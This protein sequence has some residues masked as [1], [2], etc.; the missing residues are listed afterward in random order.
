MKHRTIEALRTAIG[1]RFLADPSIFLITVP[2]WLLISVLVVPNI[3]D[4]R[5]M[6]AAVLGNLLS[7]AAFFGLLLVARD[8]VFRD[9]HLRPVSL[10]QVAL[11]GAG[12]GA[13][14]GALSVWIIDWLVPSLDYFALLPI[15]IASA[16]LVG[17]TMLAGGSLILSMRARFQ[18][19]NEALVASVDHLRLGSRPVARS[20]GADD[21]LRRIRRVLAD[22]RMTILRLGNGSVEG[23]ATRADTLRSDLRTL[24][25]ELWEKSRAS[26]DR[27]SVA[28]LLETVFSG[29]RY[30]PLPT[31]ILYTL[32]VSLP[33]TLA[34]ESFGKVIG[35]VAILFVL[36]VSTFT[37]T[38]ALPRV[39]AAWG[40]AHFVL[41]TAFIALANELVSTE[42]F[43]RLG[44]FSSAALTVANFFALALLTLISG[45]GSVALSDAN[46]VRTDLRAIYGSDYEVRILENRRLQY[47]RREL[48][49]MLHGVIQYRIAPESSHLSNEELLRTI[50][51]LA[52][53]L[54]SAEQ[55]LNG[56]NK[57]HDMTHSEL[58][59]GIRR[60]VGKWSGLL[61]VTL[62]IDIN[63]NS[64][65]SSFG[66]LL[67]AINE[68]LANSFRHGKA[69]SASVSVIG[70]KGSWLLNMTDDGLWVSDGASGLGFALFEEISSGHWSVEPRDDNGGTRL[71]IQ[72]SARREESLPQTPLGTAN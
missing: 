57:A 62:S 16:S 60:A 50:D 54:D 41:A 45:L 27:F 4:P 5:V 59:E 31:A 33:F 28:N 71:Q 65:L 6:L 3:S 12:L 38:S 64:P 17:M 55:Y 25:H 51:A 18:Q 15:R 39:R 36:I 9:R 40:V 67:S 37:A 32:I 2:L 61:D 21:E 24:S 72:I 29:H 53:D 69:G 66:Q 47:R 19:E 42:L 14:K 49:Q 23:L 30:S 46:A 1:G 56:S 34:A 68:G 13:L 44:S 8:T 63:Q 70:Q 7:L 11:V 52:E 58:E 10:T 20:V 26:Q 43:G 35:R 48:A 22:T